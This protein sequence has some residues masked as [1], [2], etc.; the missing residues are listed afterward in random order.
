M[1]AQN[2][3]TAETLG[4]SQEQQETLIKVLR[5]LESGEVRHTPPGRLPPAVGYVWPVG[6]LSGQFNMM[7]WITENECGSVCCMGGLADA[8]A[9]KNLF[10]GRHQVFG[11]EYHR[12][13]DLRELFSPR[14]V[15]SG[16]WPDITVE[17]AAAALRNYLTLGAP[18]WS[19]VLA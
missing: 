4:I 19:E 17:Q 6:K 16:Y 14:A 1:L 3:L 10:S 18:N 7:N 5:M 15:L 8:V 11:M 13:D 2:F 12:T 9:G